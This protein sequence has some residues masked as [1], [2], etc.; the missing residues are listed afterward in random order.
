MDVVVA[1]TVENVY[2]EQ[3]VIT[4]S[5]V[6]DDRK[7][8]IFDLDKSTWIDSDEVSTERREEPNL[9]YCNECGKVIG[10]SPD[11]TDYYDNPICSDCAVADINGDICPSCGRKI[12]HDLMMSGFC[13]DCFWEQ[14]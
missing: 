1:C 13:K 5:E 11:Y 12:P 10:Y 7:F 14:G 3:Y 9:V 8:H 4:S 2:D 6:L